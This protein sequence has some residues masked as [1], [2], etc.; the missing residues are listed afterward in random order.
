MKTYFYRIW[1]ALLGHNPYRPELTK[2][3]SELR[4]E[5][6]HVKDLQQLTENLRS[7]ITDKEIEISDLNVYQRDL[8]ED[9]ELTLQRLQ[10]VQRGQAYDLMAQEMLKKTNLHMGELV[11]AME[12]GEVEKLQM[13]IDREYWNKNMAHIARLHL[14]LLSQ[15]SM[16]N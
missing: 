10:E 13:F 8:R 15:Q 3:K 5:R 6:A 4:K 11:E 16:E 7:R 1:L 14:E 12:S 9:L 2:V